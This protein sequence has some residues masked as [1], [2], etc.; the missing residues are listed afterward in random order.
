MRKQHL[1]V[2]LFVLLLSACGIRMHTT[3]LV[4]EWGN[5][6][7]NDGKKE[8]QDR[9]IYKDQTV[10]VWGLEQTDCK[11][12][13]RVDSLSHSGKSCLSIEWNRTGTCPWVGFGIGWNGYAAK[14]LSEVMNTGSIDFYMRAKE[15]K[16]FIPTLIFLLE[17]YSGVQTATVLKAKQLSH[18]PIDEEWQKVS[19]PLQEFL[20]ASAPLGDF[21]NIKSLNV[22]CQ[23]AGAYF[24]DDITIGGASIGKGVKLKKGEAITKI[25]PATIFHDQLNVGWGLGVFPGREITIDAQ[26]YFDGNAALHLK[27]NQAEMGQGNRE[28]GFN[29]EHWQAISLADSLKNYALQMYIEPSGLNQLESLSI[30]F[31]SYA[32]GTVFVPLAEKYLKKANQKEGWKLV[33]IPLTD[34]DFSKGGFDTKRFKQLMFQLSGNGEMWIDEITLIEIAKNE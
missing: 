7:A 5:T 22:E 28:M 16:Q 20:N 23:G 3:E 18:Y 24:I 26:K 25:F 9:D 10:D 30:G 2:F 31:E 19:I 13:R 34:F 21:S 8:F 11:N 14:D 1:L 33:Q 17:D 29:W 32:G 6:Y 4:D 15:G 12:F 27:W